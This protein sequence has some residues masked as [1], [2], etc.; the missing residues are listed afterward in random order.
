MIAD[1]QGEPDPAMKDSFVKEDPAD[2]VDSD[3]PVNTKQQPAEG[4]V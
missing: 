3:L 1:G 4:T 2:E